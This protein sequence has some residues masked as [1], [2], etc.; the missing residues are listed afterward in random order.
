MD[1]GRASRQPDFY[2]GG[3]T[4]L[5]PAFARIALRPCR[6]PGKPRISKTSSGVIWGSPD[7][8]QVDGLVPVQQHGSA[9][10]FGAPVSCPPGSLPH[11]R[12]APRVKQHQDQRRTACEI[13]MTQRIV[14]DLQNLGLRSGDTVL[15]RCAA[16]AINVETGSPAKALFDG[17]C[18]A[19]GPTGTIVALS[20][21]SNFYF[22]QKQRAAQFPFHSRTKSETGALP[23]MVLDH[24]ASVRSKHPT[25]SFVAIGP[26]AN[27][28][29]QGHDES[30]TSFFPIRNLI[31]LGGKLLLVGCVDSSP[32][33]STVHRVQED[34]G[35]ADKILTSGMR[36]C[37][38]QEGNGIRW[39]ERKDVAGCSAGFGKFYRHYE[40]AGILSTGL[41][42]D[43]YS[44]FADAAAAYSVERT[45][46]EKDPTAAFCD[47]PC[48][49]SC[50]LRT[51]APARMTRFFLS[52]PL[53]VA[54]RFF[55]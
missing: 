11:R 27:A 33:F 15:V 35:L 23:Q 29:V 47:D 8:M 28:I 42:G 18:N 3:P 45:I 19:I 34:L 53:K 13:E 12:S 55:G 16:K 22:W 31:D 14:S 49:T 44:I 5:R 43:A 4:R 1:D 25:N 7:Q 52:V 40:S 6:E 38:V 48:C 32:G 24:P 9:T 17:I 51:Y 26:N 50:G 20:F 36:V 37:A 41:V 54:R 2:V 30:S 21:T 46:M 39:F 10:Q